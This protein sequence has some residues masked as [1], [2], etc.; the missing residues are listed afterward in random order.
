MSAMYLLPMQK[1]HLY[2]ASFYLRL[3]FASIFLFKHRLHARFGYQADVFIFRVFFYVYP[4]AMRGQQ[5]F[6]IAGPFDE[7]DPAAIEIIVQADIFHVA[8]GAPVYVQMVERQ[9]AVIFVCDRERGACDD[10]PGGYGHAF[11]ETF[12]ENRLARAQFAC[13]AVD[14][15]PAGFLAVFAP[16]A[17]RIGRRTADNGIHET[18]RSARKMEKTRRFI[19]TR[20]AI[21]TAKA[22]LYFYPVHW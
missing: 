12:G 11:G 19:L 7:G 3:P 2:G 4:D 1:I 21:Y 17:H 13:Q 14:I 5:S 8:F 15:A 10:G 18:V 16:Y 22:M 20:N 6:Y 9:A